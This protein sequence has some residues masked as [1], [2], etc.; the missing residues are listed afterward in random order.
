MKK[1]IVAICLFATPCLA[2]EDPRICAMALNSAEADASNLIRSIHMIG[3]QRDLARTDNEALQ[4]Q[5][6]NLKKQIEDLKKPDVEK[7]QAEK[8]PE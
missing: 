7:P 3:A 4:N 2:Q 8:K 6:V 1:V 5:I